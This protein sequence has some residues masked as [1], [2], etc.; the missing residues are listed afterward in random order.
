[1]AEEDD[2]QTNQQGKEDQASQPAHD[3]EGANGWS[4]WQATTWAETPAKV[5]ALSPSSLLGVDSAEVPATARA[6]SGRCGNVNHSPV[7]YPVPIIVHQVHLQLSRY[8]RFPPVRSR[9]P[10][11]LVAPAPEG[12]HAA[13][14]QSDPHD[15]YG[16]SDYS[17]YDFPLF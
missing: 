10:A 5:P 15:D 14:G 12:H 16:G 11:M 17:D 7:G 4:K 1:M 6:K 9:R 8:L 2:G 3:E 13:D